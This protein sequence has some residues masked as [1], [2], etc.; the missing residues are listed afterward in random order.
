M[1]KI[2]KCI[3]AFIMALIIAISPISTNIVFAAEDTTAPQLVSA[4]P[5]ES[6]INVASERV[7]AVVASVFNLSRL[8][9]QRLFAQKLVFINSSECLSASAELKDGD[10]VTVR[11]SGRFI[12]CGVAKTTKKGRLRV[13]IK[14]FQ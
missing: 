11:H 8:A 2:S 6:E 14:K 10:L 3:G 9:A 1:K 13:S 7:D 4:E 12:Y 5:E